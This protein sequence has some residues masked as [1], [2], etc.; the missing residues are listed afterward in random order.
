[1]VLNN[2]VCAQSADP[3]AAGSGLA[4]KAFA[5]ASCFPSSLRRVNISQVHQTCEMFRLNPRF[6]SWRAREN[7]LPSVWSCTNYPSSECGG[8]AQLVEPLVRNEKARGSNPL[9]SSPK[10][11]D[12]LD[13]KSLIPRM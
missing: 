5:P 12:A 2:A 6:P 7:P 10:N 13:P 4:A 9:T 1:M 11:L 8:I 3:A